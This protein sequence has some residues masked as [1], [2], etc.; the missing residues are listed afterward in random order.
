MLELLVY[1]GYC[2]GW[3]LPILGIAVLVVNKTCGDLLDDD[4][5]D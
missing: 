5:D 1:F 2:C 3:L 4:L